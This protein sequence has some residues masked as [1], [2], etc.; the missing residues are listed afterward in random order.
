M[1]FVKGKGGGRPVGSINRN[2]LFV[3]E[4]IERVL[5]MSLPEKILEQVKLLKP[6]D[7][8][9]YYEKLMKYS[10]PTLTSTEISGD[11]NITPV[12]NNEQV[13]EEL[14]KALERK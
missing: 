8:T 4:T 6:A 3:R 10:Y 9:Y 2:A 14:K 1:P 12:T 5:G 7:Q 13:A 11:I